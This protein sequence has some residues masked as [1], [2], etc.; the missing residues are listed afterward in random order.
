MARRAQ[1]PQHQAVPA[2][3]PRSSAAALIA[4]PTDAEIAIGHALTALR[5]GEAVRIGALGDTGC[6]KSRLMRAIIARYLTTVPGVVFVVD[7]GGGEASWGGQ[8]YGWPADLAS[9]PPQPEPRVV[10]FT[11]DGAGD[12]AI[13]IAVCELAW[14]YGERGWP[15]LVVLDEVADA[16]HPQAPGVW[17]SA[18]GQA[19]ARLFKQG[20]KVK[21]SVAWATQ[22]PQEVPL[23]LLNE[24]E[25]VFAFR[26]A[27][28]A[29]NN[30]RKKDFTDAAT[31]A[32]LKVLPDTKSP[33]KQRG[34]H[35]RLQRGHSWDGRVYRVLG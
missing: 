31:E 19:I 14:T 30:L 17:R 2:Q 29:L 1:Q 9:K 32:V 22:F 24:T 21:V 4:N 20:R 5:Y 16:V 35:L 10:V 7:Q 26:L 11:G 23:A 34:A 13:M 25:D 15:V 18:G 27:G 6:G 28:S 33:P 3:A 8:V 12:D